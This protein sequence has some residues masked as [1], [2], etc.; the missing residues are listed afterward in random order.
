MKYF[1]NYHRILLKPFWIL[2]L[3]FIMMQSGFCQG[4]TSSIGDREN[5]GIYGGPAKDLAYIFDNHRLFAAMNS[6]GV[7]FYS[8]DTCKTWSPAFP[9]DSLEYDFGARGWGGAGKRVLSNEKGWVFVKTINENAFSSAVVSYDYGDP[10][11]FGTAIDPYMLENITGEYQPVT[12][13]DLTDHYA[14]IGMGKYL[15]RVNDTSS[16]K[17]GNILIN[18]ETV[19]GITI[20]SSI[21]SIAAS[22]NPSGYPVYVVVEP[23]MG[24][25]NGV[26]YSYD[27]TI[28]SMISSI[29]PDFFV[30]NVFT[31]AGAPSGDTAFISCRQSATQNIIL[32]RTTDGWL[33]FFDITPVG[34]T[35]DYI[36]DAD[37]SPLWQTQ[38]PLSN[39]LRLSLPGGRISD[40]LGDTWSTKPLQKY[41]IASHPIDPYLIVGS[42]YTGPV[43]S[44]NGIQ[45]PF[46]LHDNIGLEN[47]HVNNFSES[48]GVYYVATDAGLAYTDNYAN[49]G[50]SDFEKWSFPYGI[51]PVPNTGDQEG[52]SAVAVNPFDSL[53]VI[54][55][56]KG[57]FNVSFSGPNGFFDV[58]PVGWNNNPHD[59]PYVTD[60]KFVA[61]NIILALT[62]YK[63][64]DP[65]TPPI[66]VVG[67][68]WK[69]DD[70]GITWYLVTPY[71]P[72]E[73]EMGNCLEV[74][75]D[76]F[77]QVIYAGSG[78][79]S[80][81]SPP[82]QGGLWK[83]FDEGNSWT[84]INDGP[85]NGYGMP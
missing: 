27:G 63:F 28:F 77:Q 37:Y 22:N 16:F 48:M 72:D 80:E 4:P 11:T 71:F 31:H 8:D 76:G 12:S 33:S 52:V 40:D 56:F 61:P 34:G 85:M 47:V 57:G 42:I 10:N 35:N 2:I 19:P 51:F 32:L 83:S 60:I 24:I 45:G 65:E 73:F 17:S 15:V 78:H 6:A 30:N 23:D 1:A 49:G 66:Q 39:G 59:D 36:S 29:P 18:I 67:N 70:G 3:T 84:K 75:F 79:F 50:I 55:G 62:G 25:G 53:H 68:I 20:G 9:F 13:I 54:C 26:L 74:T 38:M 44:L 46:V 82:V 64:R 5:L 43:V 81:A 14:Y 69:S 58:I 7:L 41:G 21:R